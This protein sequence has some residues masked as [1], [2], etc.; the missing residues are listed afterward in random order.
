MDSKL[1]QNPELTRD[2]SFI[3]AHRR[4]SQPPLARY[5]QRRVALRVN[6]WAHDMACWG[7]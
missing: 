7:I 2:T 1:L 6:V 4:Q 5:G 3:A